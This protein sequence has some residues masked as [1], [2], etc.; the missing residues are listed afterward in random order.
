MRILFIDVV[1]ARL[2]V[3]FISDSQ[4]IWQILG[5]RDLAVTLAGGDQVFVADDGMFRFDRGFRL[6]TAADQP[7][8]NYIAGRQGQVEFWGP[9]I[10]MGPNETDARVDIE[11]LFVDFLYFPGWLPEDPRNPGSTSF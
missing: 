10:V 7:F 11:D 3:M 5:V 2:E 6:R 1:K 8:P 4:T 9:G